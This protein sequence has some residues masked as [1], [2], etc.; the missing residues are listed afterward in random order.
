[1]GS[2]VTVTGAAAVPLAALFVITISL[3]GGSLA[4]RTMH[5]EYGVYH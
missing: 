4:G 1:M 2:E 5:H 3:C